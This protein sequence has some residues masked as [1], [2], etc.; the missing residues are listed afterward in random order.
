[1]NMRVVKTLIVFVGLAAIALVALVRA[2]SAHGQREDDFVRRARELAVLA[3]GGATLGA[4]VHDV[5]SAEAGGDRPAGVVIDEVQPGSPA[6]KAGLKRGDVLVEFDGERVR[7]ARQFGR[8][9]QETAPGRAVKA[10]M[11]RDGRRTDIEVTPAGAD[12]RSG[13]LM[14]HGD[15][16]NYM[17]DFGH[18]LGRLGDRFNFDFDLDVMGGGRRLGVTVEQ[19]TSQLADYF[20]AKEGLLVTSVADGSAASR[21]GLKA[22]DV[23]TTV[24]GRAIHSRQD[25]LSA[26]RE[27]RGDEV[28]IGIVREKKETTIKAKVE[29]RRTTRRKN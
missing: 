22:G 26:L 19:L 13:D 24:D 16:G 12:G 9:V 4:T 29:A 20:A 7:S 6:E 28:S 27:A 25:L 3:G 5:P 21:A 2:P 10:T 1:M 14:I 17:R 18:D 11:M 23:I 8:L 15:F